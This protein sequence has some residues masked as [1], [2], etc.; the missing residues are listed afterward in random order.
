MSDLVFA[1]VL[2]EPRTATN[3]H[4]HNHWELVCYVQGSGVI[5]VGGQ[6]IPFA[7]GTIIALP[8]DIPHDEVSPGGFRCQF[9]GVRGPTRRGPI[10]LCQDDEHGSFRSTCD[11][12]IRECWQR[13]SGWEATGEDVVRLLWRL[14]DRWSGAGDDLVRQAEG[15]LLAQLSDPEL[16]IATIARRL[17]VHEEQLRRRFT[18]AT[19][20]SPR[21]HLTRLRIEAARQ[22]LAHGSSVSDTATACG[23]ADPFHFSKAFRVATGRPPSAL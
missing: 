14:I 11:L 4:V 16:R 7:P 22:L 1:G 13:P 10:P 2:P 23:F 3:R 19:G 5:T 6:R 12:L 15:L 21:A 20:R 17:G 8:P 9:V 18:A